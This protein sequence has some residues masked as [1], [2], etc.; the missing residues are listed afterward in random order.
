M[1]YVESVF[2]GVDRRPVLSSPGKIDYVQEHPVE[3]G[4]ASC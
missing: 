1:S 3:A 4:R 2:I